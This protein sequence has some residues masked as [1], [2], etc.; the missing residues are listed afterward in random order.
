MNDQKITIEHI[1]CIISSNLLDEMDFVIG[2]Y[3]KPSVEFI[4]NFNAFVE[5]YILSSHF[6]LTHRE[7]EHINIIKKVLFPNGRPIFE[8]LMKSNKV[9]VYSGFGDNIMQCVYVD[10]VSN[11]VN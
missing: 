5:S 1:F 10:K 6:I 11:S 7:V 4:F 3:G 9:S 8:L 2:G